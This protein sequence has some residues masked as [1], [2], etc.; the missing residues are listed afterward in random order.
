MEFIDHLTIGIYVDR[1][2]DF[3]DLLKMR[4][5]TDKASAYATLYETLVEFS[6]ILAP[7]LPFLSDDVPTFGVDM[8]EM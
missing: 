2:E 8:E 5:Q 7:V 1:D 4:V 6:K 3:G